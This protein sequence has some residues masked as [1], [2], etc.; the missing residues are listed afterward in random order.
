ME[1]AGGAIVSAHDPITSSGAPAEPCHGGA[2]APPSPLATDAHGYLLAPGV[3]RRGGR[4]FVSVRA[5]ELEAIETMAALGNAD[6]AQLAAR[7][8]RQAAA[9][10]VAAPAGRWARFDVLDEAHEHADAGGIAVYVFSDLG[11]PTLGRGAQDALARGEQ[12]GL[13]F[14]VDASALETAAEAIGCNR[15]WIRTLGVNGRARF[16]IHGAILERA[17]AACAR[18]PA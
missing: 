3:T 11:P 18:R 1:A 10:A 2:G 12:V 6:M 16:E 8:R 7:V 15:K 5:V 9:H 17:L 14:A 13:L 4:A